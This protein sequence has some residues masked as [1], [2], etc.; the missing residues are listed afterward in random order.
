[1]EKVKI[2]SG[3]GEEGDED[4]CFQRLESSINSWL[5]DNL[6]IEI[7]SRQIGVASGVNMKKEVFV[8]CT[9]VIFYRVV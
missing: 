8:N 2:F 1:M 3:A 5:E 4:E 7:V 9:V 6:N